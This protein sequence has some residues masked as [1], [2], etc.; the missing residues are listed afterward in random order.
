MVFRLI[1]AAVLSIALMVSAGSRVVPMDDGTAAASLH[2]V[3]A[4]AGHGDHAGHGL[5]QMADADADGC[6]PK[7]H[8]LDCTTHCPAFAIVL[9]A[10]VLDLSGASRSFAAYQ[11]STERG[12]P[13]I[14]DRPPEAV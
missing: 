11:D 13:A 2:H 10:P 12:L 3:T 6:S 1:L 5:D 9:T 8:C 7:S 14:A 4:A